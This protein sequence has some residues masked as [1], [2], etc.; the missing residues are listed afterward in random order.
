MQKT[1]YHV[2]R[3]TNRE[4]ILAQ[5]LE[6]RL[7]EALE[8]K[9]APAVYLLSTLEQAKDYGFWFALHEKCDLDIWQVQLGPECVVS[10]D[11]SKDMAIYESWYVTAK[12][13][14][15]C[16]SMNSVIPAPTSVSQAPPFIRLRP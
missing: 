15:E 7:Q 13:P 11:K 8:V 12:I 6:P 10:S 4:G 16:L 3:R 9:R 14:A 5:G 2:S 1:Y